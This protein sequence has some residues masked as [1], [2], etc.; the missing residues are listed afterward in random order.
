MTLIAFATYGKHRAEI[1]TDTSTWT[2][3]LRSIGNTSKVLT[4]PHI[5]TAIC[6]AGDSVFSYTA[7]LS[8]LDMSNNLDLDGLVESAPQ[9]FTDNLATATAID[10][11]G[12]RVGTCVVFMVGWSSRRERF[13]AF[14]FDSK[15]DFKPYDIPGMFIIPTPGFSVRPSDWELRRLAEQLHPDDVVWLRQ[16]PVPTKPANLGEWIDYALAAREQRTLMPQM[17]EAGMAV[18][19]GGQLWHTT[20]ERGRVHSDLVHE[21]DTEGEE[22]AR[23]IAG[24]LHPQS[25]LGPC[26]CGSGKRFIDCCLDLDNPC[27][28]GSGRPVRD[29]CAVTAS[30]QPIA[31]AEAGTER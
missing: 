16:Q 27:S 19:V 2:F 18:Y 9:Q 30:G 20:L 25:Q 28:C 26:Q 15:D 3:N 14:G 17:R 12:V 29:C 13:V 23:S 6:T 22:W 11:G 8:V 7:Q 21:F 24:S 4:L 1:L 31:A 5:S 10:R